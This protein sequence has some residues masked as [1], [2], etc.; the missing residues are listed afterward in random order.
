MNKHLIDEIKDLSMLIK[1]KDEQIK[2]LVEALEKIIKEGIDTST[3]GGMDFC[4]EA[5]KAVKGEM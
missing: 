1:K 4:S 3:D 5:L 2:I